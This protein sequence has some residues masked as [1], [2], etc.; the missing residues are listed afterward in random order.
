MRGLLEWEVKVEVEARPRSSFTVAGLQGQWM[1]RAEL[2][3]VGDGRG[4]EG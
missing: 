1:G 2:C 3:I 4:G